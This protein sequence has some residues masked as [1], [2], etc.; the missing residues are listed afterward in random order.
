VEGALTTCDEACAYIGDCHGF[1]DE[2][3]GQDLISCRDGCSTA[4]AGDL[5]VVLDCLNG[6]ACSAPQAIAACDPDQE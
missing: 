6:T 1:E 2:A 5:Q 4:S 3:F